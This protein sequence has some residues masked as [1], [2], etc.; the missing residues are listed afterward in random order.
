MLPSGHDTRL[1]D[2]DLANHNLP[3]VLINVVD[4]VAVRPSFLVAADKLV[5]RP[6]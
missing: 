6:W 1:K 4:P 2:Y 5:L 3:A